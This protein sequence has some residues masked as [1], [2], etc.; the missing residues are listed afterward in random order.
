MLCEIPRRSGCDG[1]VKFYRDI[2]AVVMSIMFDL[3][4]FKDD[5]VTN[6]IFNIQLNSIQFNSNQLLEFQIDFFNAGLG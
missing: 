6:S 3:R 1:Q 4:V 5:L 2:I